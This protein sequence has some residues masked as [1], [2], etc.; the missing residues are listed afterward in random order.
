[1]AGVIEKYA[2]NPITIRRRVGIID[3]QPEWEEFAA[4]AMMFDFTQSDIDYFTSSGIKRGGNL[5]SIKN[6]KVFLVSPAIGQAPELPGQVLHDGKTYDIQG[7]KTYRNLKG[8][9]LGY[10][11]AVAGGA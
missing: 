6:G 9:L 10:R 2:N 8:Q 11:V 5:G 4:L 1:M 3:G 7:V